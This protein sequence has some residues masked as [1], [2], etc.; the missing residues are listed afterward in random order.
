MIY[1]INFSPFLAI[2]QLYNQ[3]ANLKAENKINNNL[4]LLS[5]SLSLYIYIY[6]P[7]VQL[8]S[9]TLFSNTKD[10][11]DEIKFKIEQISFTSLKLLPVR[12]ITLHKEGRHFTPTNRSSDFLPLRYIKVRGGGIEPAVFQRKHGIRLACLQTVGWICKRNGRRFNSQS[13]H[14]P[15]N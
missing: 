15:P 6:F 4:F 1:D 5:L 9:K 10:K 13:V 7:L 14:P 12:R 2:C 11:T 8:N 3:S